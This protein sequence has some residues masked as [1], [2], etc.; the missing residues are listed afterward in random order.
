MNFERVVETVTDLQCFAPGMLSAGARIDRIRL[1]LNRWVQSGK[2][3][4][5]HKGWYT[6]SE[7]FRR[8]KLDPFI[9]ACAL[10]AGTY[11]SLQSALSYR[12]F[13]PE[14][15]P[16]I[17]CV[18]TG[19]P[20]LIETPFWRIRYRHMKPETFWGFQQE[21]HGTQNAFVAYA[22]KALLDLIYLTPGAANRNYL[23]ELRL[24]NFENL[25]QSTLQ[26]MTR[27]FGRPKLRGVPNI[28]AGLRDNAD[29]YSR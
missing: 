22:E 1:Q 2:V 21:T 17:T 26:Q 14:N 20:Q 29:G 11:I 10:K 19:R 23:T 9:V 6:L 25:N 16:E 7:P 4:R 15:V 27:R 5:I 8:V 3:I 13:I 28:I 18:T 12:G 24:Q